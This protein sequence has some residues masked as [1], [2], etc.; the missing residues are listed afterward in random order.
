MLEPITLLIA[1]ELLPASAAVTLTASSGRLV[2][3]DTIV[4]PI[5]SGG[6]FNLFATAELPSTKAS[7]PLIRNINPTTSDITDVIIDVSILHSPYD[8]KQLV[9]FYHIEF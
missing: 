3:R 6:T 9:P 7:A 1:S 8:N 2:P 4:K 5:I